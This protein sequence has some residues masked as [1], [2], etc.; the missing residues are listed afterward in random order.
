[1]PLAKTTATEALASVAGTVLDQ[2]GAAVPGADVSLMHRDGTQLHTMGSDAGGE[3]NFIKILPG[4]YLV[5]VNAKGFALF[6]SAEFAVAA[7]GL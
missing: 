4:S 3:F 1:M 6:T 5:T 7:Q 2:S